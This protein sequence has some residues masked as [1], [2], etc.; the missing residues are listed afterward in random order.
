[1]KNREFWDLRCDK[2]GHTGWSDAKIYGYDQPLRVRVISDYCARIGAPP[3]SPALDF[4]CGSGDMAA[5]LC[6]KFD[7]VVAAD[8]SMAALNAAANKHCEP[9]LQFVDIESIPSELRFGLVLAVTVFQHIVDDADLLQTL[10][11]HHARLLPGGCLVVLDSF[12]DTP[13]EHSYMKLR[14]VSDM[15]RLSQD[16]GFELR[17]EAAFYSP[18]DAP[19]PEYRRYAGSLVTRL[20]VRLSSVPFVSARLLPVWS[21]WCSRNDPGFCT[22][23]SPMRLLCLQ[24]PALLAD[25]GARFGVQ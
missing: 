5:A 21:R 19:S 4:G 1:M 18:I 16:A 24:R 9:N 7:R 17:D 12:A 25:N 6:R 15:L 20:L 22:Q 13:V 14:R 23:A 11:A 2:H 10:K 3:G 8:I